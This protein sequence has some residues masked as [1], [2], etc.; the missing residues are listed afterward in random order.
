M[1]KNER[2]NQILDLLKEKG[3]MSVA[4][5]SK[6]LFASQSSIRRDLTNL[7]KKGIVRRSYGGAEL[8]VSKSNIL[9]FTTRAYDS[10]A[11]KQIIAKKA[12]GLVKDG[13]V[14]FLDQSSTCYF[15]A[16]ELIDKKGITVVTNSLII[17]NFLSLTDLKVISTGGILSRE[18]RTCLVGE[19]AEKTY[20]SIFADIAFFSTKSLSSDGIISDCTQEEISVRKI[21]LK[22]S[23]KRVYLCNS[24]KFDT[25]SPYIQCSLSEVDI[26]I[27]EDTAK[28]YEKY[29]EIR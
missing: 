6:M 18:D 7:E 22:N 27:S 21:M 29:C 19:G 24:A 12:A 17:L 25:K 4:N 26:L 8:I 5:L 3:F 11:E 9:P 20:D 28:R 16:M 15:L 14:I 10:V 23:S 13:D 1:L 2:E